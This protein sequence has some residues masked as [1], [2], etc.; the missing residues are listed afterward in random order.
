MTSPWWLDGA[1]ARLARL[2]TRP[3]GPDHIFQRLSGVD[4]V[5]LPITTDGLHTIGVAMLE[6]LPTDGSWL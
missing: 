6:I 4:V 1:A 3:P 5:A 2:T